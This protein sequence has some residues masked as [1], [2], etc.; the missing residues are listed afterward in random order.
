MFQENNSRWGKFI[1]FLFKKRVLI[2]LLVIVA[3]VGGTYTYSRYTSRRE[4]TGEATVAKWAVKIGPAATNKS[5]GGFTISFQDKTNSSNVMEN[6]IAPGSEL[7]ADFEIDPTG[8]EVSIDYSFEL[9]ALKVKEG[10]TGTVPTGLTISKVCKVETDNSETVLSN[11]NN[12]YT[13]TISLHNTNTPLAASD[14][15][16]V[17]VYIKWT[18]SNDDDDTAAGVNPATLTIPVTGTAEQHIDP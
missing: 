11:T 13:G 7:C 9:G 17:R 4:G 12:K 16:K 6:K 10:T 1:L 8:S 18:G 5:D 15:V 14:K 2:T 3:G